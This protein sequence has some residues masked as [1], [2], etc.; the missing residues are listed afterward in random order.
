VWHTGVR[1]A[2]Q[3]SAGVQRQCCGTLASSTQLWLQQHPTRATAHL[4]SCWS[5]RLC[6]WRIRPAVHPLRACACPSPPGCSGPQRSAAPAGGLQPGRDWVPW[7]RCPCAVTA[8]AAPRCSPCCEDATKRLFSGVRDQISAA[9]RVNCNCAQCARCSKSQVHLLQPLRALDGQ[10]GRKQ[11]AHKAMLSSFV[12]STY[13]PTL[14][15]AYRMHFQTG[16]LE[17]CTG[18]S[19]RSVKASNT[20]GRPVSGN[21]PVSDQRR[22]NR[23]LHRSCNVK[24]EAP[25]GHSPAFAACLATGLHCQQC[26]SRVRTESSHLQSIFATSVTISHRLQHACGASANQAA[27]SNATCCAS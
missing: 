11:S 26:R 3:C 5:H 4:Q 9:L 21:L 23:D 2:P 24:C 16:K 14:Q 7:L 27:P 1:V 8:Q 17:E 19:T 20:H 18:Q 25:K 22:T 13:P 15:Q 12:M 10:R 6:L